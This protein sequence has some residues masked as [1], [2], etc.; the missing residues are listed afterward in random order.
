MFKVD[1]FVARARPYD[2]EA[3][4]RARPEPLTGAASTLH[5]FVAS[6]EDTILAKLEWFRQGGETSERQWA[7][8]VGICR[9]QASRLDSTYLNRWAAALGVGDLLARARDEAG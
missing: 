9:T 2:R 3:L 7:D 1:V 5:A 4:A 6:A 8:V